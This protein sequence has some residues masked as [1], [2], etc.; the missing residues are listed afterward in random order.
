MTRTELS[1]ILEKHRKWLLGD[2]DGQRAELRYANLSELNL[3]G[4]NLRG[5]NLSEADLREADLRW[6][7]LRA[8]NLCGAYLNGADLREANLLDCSLPLGCGGLHITL[9]RWQMTQLI[10]QF[11]SLN[12]DDPEVLEVQKSMYALAN[13]FAESREDLKDKKFQEVG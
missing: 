5:A 10:Y 3:R 4:A 13:E 7:D 1:K 2:A 11:C 9:S 12:C 8:T 6:A